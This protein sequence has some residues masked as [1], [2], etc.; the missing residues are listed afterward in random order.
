MSSIDFII[1][2]LFVMVPETF[3]LTCN[4]L[5][6]LK[7][8]DLFYKRNIKK[9]VINIILFI[10]IPYSICGSVLYNFNMNIY[11][12]LLLNSLC[13][14]ILL[15]IVLGYFSSK[16]FIK[17]QII[18]GVKLY[19]YSLLPL[20][21][22]YTI[23][24]ISIVILKYLFNFDSSLI[25]I[26]ISVNFLLTIVTKLVLGF[27]TYINY[28]IY[29][30]DNNFALGMFWSRKI[31]LKQVIY[32]Q[33]IINIA[34]VIF[35]H[36]R[37]ILNNSYV[38]K[39]IFI[40]YMFILVEALIPWFIIVYLTLSQKKKAIRYI[41]VNKNLF[42]R[43]ENSLYNHYKSLMKVRDL[44]LEVS[45]LDIKRNIIRN[46]I[47]EIFMFMDLDFRD[48][49]N[50]EANI[51]EENITEKN[52]ILE[53]K[54]LNQ[55]ISLIDQKI[56]MEKNIIKKIQDKLSELECRIKY[57]NEEEKYI[58][59]YKYKEYKSD[60]WISVRLLK[61]VDEIIEKRVELVE[62]IFKN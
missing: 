50:G 29:N 10:T 18:D 37:F 53:T 56:D 26:D 27:I 62:S 2:F 1:K 42:N 59:K 34:L 58:L 61:S 31:L 4:T 35:I 12:R 25:A 49:L 19:L 41:T 55:K 39:Q 40:I 3:L 30:F 60:K 21:F 17:E 45:N 6:L 57:L 33:M 47:E 38:N 23:E 15:Y 52:V 22:L 28:A 54:K 32:F 20:L 8:N 43:F 9:V 51:K 36:D 14:C 7:R 48:K 24:I 44:N 46:E 5:I 11:I 13:L 16:K